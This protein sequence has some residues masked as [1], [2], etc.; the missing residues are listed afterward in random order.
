[1]SVKALA[2]AFY[3]R[4]EMVVIDDILSTLDRGTAN[5]LFASVFGA[6][7]IIKRSKSTVVLATPTAEYISA[8]DQVI[9]VSNEGNVSSRYNLKKSDLSKSFLQQLSEGQEAKKDMNSMA[10]T[11]QAISPP[12]ELDTASQEPNG[13]SLALWAYYLKPVSKTSLLGFVFLIIL[14]TLAEM[15]CG[16]L[17]S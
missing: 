10:I 1:M 4:A 5:L 7:G 11:R 9:M 6:Q 14:L 17:A 3:S 15:S 8:A 13:G 16:K 2:R 12:S